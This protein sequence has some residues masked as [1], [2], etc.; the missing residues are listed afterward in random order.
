MKKRLFAALALAGIA[1]LGSAVAA[2]G[3]DVTF[4]IQVTS[5]AI[6]GNKEISS[7]DILKAV[8]LKVGATL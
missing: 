2:W 6:D 4:P 1:L 5:I 8:P 3:A 7:R